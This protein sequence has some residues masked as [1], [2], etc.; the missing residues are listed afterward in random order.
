MSAAEVESGSTVRVT[1]QLPAAIYNTLGARAVLAGR[2][3]EQAI[4]DHV[5]RTASFT[6][7]N[8]YYFDD[9]QST[10]IRELLGTRSASSQSV[11][12]AVEILVSLGLGGGRVRL[13][14]EQQEA[15]KIRAKA[16]G[17]DMRDPAKVAASVS[18]DIGNAV[19]RLLQTR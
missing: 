13:S 11:V 15:L 9:K 5:A 12:E 8:P 14:L 6:A 16:K 2:S 7:D 4:A 3:P 1:I 18:E 10:R 19:A 17:V